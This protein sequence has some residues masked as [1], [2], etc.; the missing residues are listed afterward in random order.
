MNA[1]TFPWES[2]YKEKI[3]NEMEVY[4]FRIAA[5]SQDLV[6]WETKQR[7]KPGINANSC[8]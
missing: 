7:D 8:L 6:E 4:T 5:K 2:W 1:D 3:E